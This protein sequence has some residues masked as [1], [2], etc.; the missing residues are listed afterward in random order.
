MKNIL[1][2]KEEFKLFNE[3]DQFGFF[4][5]EDGFPTDDA[6]MKFDSNVDELFEKFTSICIDAEDNIYGI[7]NGS[8]ELLMEN[9]TEAYDIAKEVKEG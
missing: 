2:A 9:A 8:K 7:N 1:L 3:D 6:E 5:N 4:Y